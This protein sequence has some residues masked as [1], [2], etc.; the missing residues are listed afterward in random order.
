M[1]RAETTACALASQLA[2][3]GV[4]IILD[5][6]S[7]VKATRIKRKGVVK[8]QDYRDIG[9]HN[10]SSK[11]LTIRWTPGHRTLEQAT[12]YSDYQDMQGNN[13]SGVLSNMG[14]NLPM[15]SQQ[16][17]PHDIVSIGARGESVVIKGKVHLLEDQATE[18]DRHL[19]ASR[20]ERQRADELPKERETKLLSERAVAN[21]AEAGWGTCER[22]LLDDLV[23]ARGQRWTNRT[24][25]DAVQDPAVLEDKAWLTQCAIALRTG[26][27]RAAT[28]TALLEDGLKRAD[29]CKVTAPPPSFAAHQDRLLHKYD[30]TNIL[31]SSKK[32]GAN[33]PLTSVGGSPRSQ[34]SGAHGSGAW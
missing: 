7:V 16:P 34:G 19:V 9:Y 18:R 3:R 30:V 1:C 4:D 25:P 26:L 28:A 20:R 33:E 2:S 31:Q 6:Q 15:D 29:K 14:D 21:K 27:Q 17:Q 32:K 12:T 10:T 23:T 24:A 5:N 13:H 11:R 8:D 22:K